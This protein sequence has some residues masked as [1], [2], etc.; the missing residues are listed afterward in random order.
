MAV[1]SRIQLKNWFKRGLKPLEAQFADWI[2]S[3]WHQSE[4][5]IPISAINGLETLLNSYAVATA[6]TAS[7]DA[8]KDGVP[9]EG[10]TLNKLYNLIASLGE[11]VGDHDAS[12][13][14]PTTGTGEGGAIDKGDY[15]HITTA[16]TIA[17]LGDL[18]VGDVLFAK[19]DNAS[20]AADFFYLP[21]ASLVAA[22]TD[23]AA[24]ILEIADQSENE[25]AAT[26]GTAAGA[27]YTRAVTPRGLWWFWA[28]IKTLAVTFTNTLKAKQIA[29]T[30]GVLT[31]A[32][33]IAWDG[34]TIGNLAQV[35][36]GGN[37]TLGAITNPVSGAIYVLRII[38]DAT[39][40][41]TLAFN[42]AYTFPDGIIPVLNSGANA[43]TTLSFFYDGTAFRLM[44]NGGGRIKLSDL[45]LANQAASA[46]TYK[47]VYVD[48]TGKVI[49]EVNMAVDPTN[50]SLTVKGIDQLSSHFTLLLQ[51]SLGN[52]V[53]KFRNDQVVEFGG[54]PKITIPA[55]TLS[56]VA[57][58]QFLANQSMAFRIGD[59]STDWIVFESTTGAPL[60]RMLK[61]IKY[62]QG[63]GFE[64]YKYQFFA[65]V[66]T[67]AGADTVIGSLSLPAGKKATVYAKVIASD[68]ADNTMGGDILG[69]FKNTA[70]NTLSRIGHTQRISADLTATAKLVAN[71]TSKVIEF[72]FTN[73]TGT[74]HAY[75][76]CFEVDIVIQTSP[77]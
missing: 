59:G 18:A 37:R 31:D 21:F 65:S 39:G 72:T 63:V 22:A 62:N 52:T 16:G 9:S 43:V 70:G 67:T 51:D 36:L 8:L 61:P 6:V 75:D 3:F 60:V 44:A 7:L 64:S 48:D 28:K 2:D 27:D 15:W 19:A 41:R 66:G 1:Q 77:A 10:D 38:Q 33:T 40:G 5:S 74:G 47:L 23:T 50:H 4:D 24:G 46:G 26:S 13:G 14:L 49:K 56:G 68:N 12:T 17:G 76:V 11:L 58:F 25:I 32:A 53:A 54:T 45:L 42:A 20:V 30:F 35:T 69:V 57:L 34:S 55:G 71:N 29:G 73:D